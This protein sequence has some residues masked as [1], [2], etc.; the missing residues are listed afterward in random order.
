MYPAR[1]FI[2]ESATFA[3]KHETRMMPAV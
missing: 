3:K 2:K 1:R